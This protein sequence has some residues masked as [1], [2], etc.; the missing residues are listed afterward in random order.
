MLMEWGKGGSG[1]GQETFPYSTDIHRAAV[2]ASD[3][4]KNYG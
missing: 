4:S 1:H 3:C 2:G